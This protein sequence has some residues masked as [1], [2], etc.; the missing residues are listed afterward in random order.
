MKSLD[1]NW[2]PGCA[3]HVFKGQSTIYPLRVSDFYI[4]P[5]KI[6]MLK[7]ILLRFQIL[8]NKPSTGIRKTKNLRGSI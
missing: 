7:S 2:S 3:L 4:Y 1:F 6:A 8:T 5:S